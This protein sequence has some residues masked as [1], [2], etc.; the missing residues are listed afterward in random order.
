HLL[1]TRATKSPRAF[2]FG[3]KPCTRL[4]LAH[5]NFVHS[6]ICL[7]GGGPDAP[8]PTTRSGALKSKSST[9][10]G[11]S[12]LFHASCSTVSSNTIHLPSFH[13]LVTSPTRIPQFSGT[14]RPR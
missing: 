7:G 10:R 2:T 3:R 6:P 13:V 8:G 14:I 1:F 11:L 9:I 12:L 4:R 5:T